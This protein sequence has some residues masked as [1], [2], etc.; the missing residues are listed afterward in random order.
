MSSLGGLAI[1][2]IGVALLSHLVIIVFVV[3]GAMTGRRSLWLRN[4]LF[5][6]FGALV[7]GVGLLALSFAITESIAGV[8]AGALVILM[9]LSLISAAWAS[10]YRATRDGA[11]HE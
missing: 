6:S 1:A 8:V 3:R 2:V 11:S 4:A 9:G 5:T 10:N 7:A